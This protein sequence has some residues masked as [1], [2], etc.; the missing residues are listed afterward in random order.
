[1]HKIINVIITVVSI[2]VFVNIFIGVIDLIL[3][4]AT[5]PLWVIITM[6][7]PYGVIIVPQFRHLN[8]YVK[9]LVFLLISAVNYVFLYIYNQ[10]YLSSVG[11]L[12]S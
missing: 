3:S 12:A 5:I 9:W 4:S 10:E 6:I 2:Y 8:I 1:M 7:L 11:L